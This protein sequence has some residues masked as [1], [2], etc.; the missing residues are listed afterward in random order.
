MEVVLLFGRVS[1]FLCHNTFTLE[2]FKTADFSQNPKFKIFNMYV[3]IYFTKN[4]M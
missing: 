1:I 2:N 3:E 4:N